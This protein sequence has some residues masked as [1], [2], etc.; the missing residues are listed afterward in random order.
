MDKI[1]S[2]PGRVVNGAATATGSLLTAYLATRYGMPIELAGAAGLAVGG[3]QAVLG[4][5]VRD[6]AEKQPPKTF[7]GALLVGLFS[8]IG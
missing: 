8:R 1:V 3:A 5:A 2:T 6:A 4:S 7:I